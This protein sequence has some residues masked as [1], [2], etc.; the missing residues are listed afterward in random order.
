MPRWGL[1]YDDLRRVNPQ[2]IMA[3]MPGLGLEG[4]HAHYRGLG[5]YFQARTGLDSLTGF[6]N[7]PTVDLGYA[8]PDGACNPDHIATA[9]LAAL[10]YRNRTGKGQF[11]E[12]SQ[13]ES[14]VN[15]L[16]TALFENLVNGTERTRTG[17]RHPTTAPY[18]IYRCKGE[19]EWC[20]ITVFTDAEWQALCHAAGYPEWQADP[21]FATVVARKKHED[22]LDSAI[23]EWTSTKSPQE[24]ME[25]LQAAGVIAGAFQDHSDLLGSDP[26]MAHRGF[27]VEL[28]HSEMGRLHHEAMPYRLSAT[29][30]RL[31]RPAPISGQ[32][33]DFVLQEV[34][35]VPEDEINQYIV[36]R[37]VMA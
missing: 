17:N 37:A 5:S 33:T 27:Y 30:W 25:I 20:A 19:D 12:L 16:E 6:P 2:I 32:E 15:F 4:P 11:I 10:H 14:A 24:V 13:F 7:R 18:G 26:Q 21:R 31:D 29:P 36:E 9:I 35:G 23:T 22:E 3:R 34:I 28:E 8:Y 1:S